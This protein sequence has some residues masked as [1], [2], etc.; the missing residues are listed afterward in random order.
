MLHTYT[1]KNRC[2]RAIAHHLMLCSPR[3]VLHVRSSTRRPV[4][5]CAQSVYGGTNSC[6]FFLDIGVQHE[7]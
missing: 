3:T 1:G 2:A 4:R 5:A 7:G 6:A